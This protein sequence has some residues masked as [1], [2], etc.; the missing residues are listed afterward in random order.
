[1]QKMQK[2][3]NLKGE[4]M[5]KEIIMN[6]DIEIEKAK[7]AYE[8]AVTGTATQDQIDELRGKLG[9][10]EVIKEENGSFKITFKKFN[11]KEE[12][13]IQESAMGIRGGVKSSSAGMITTPSIQNSTT[14]SI[15]YGIK[16][17]EPRIFDFT[18]ETVIAQLDKTLKD[19]IY[20]IV[21]D[22]NTK[23]WMF[24]QTVG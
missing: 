9:N 21:E 19:W 1:M 8:E 22:F 12:A 20:N 18:N 3:Q 7:K 2:A 24:R 11:L 17:I 10:L 16:N 15:M 6:L 14:K 5:V 4:N 13:I 23:N